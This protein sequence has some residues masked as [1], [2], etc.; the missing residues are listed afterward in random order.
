[1]SAPGDVHVHLQQLLEDLAALGG[2]IPDLARS[3]P[4]GARMIGDAKASE[5]PE[6]TA[7]QD[8]LAA[9]VRRLARSP[10]RQPDHLLVACSTARDAAAWAD[11]LTK[12]AQ[13][14]GL[15]VIDCRVHELACR[16]HI[17]RIVVTPV[18]T[19]APPLDD[20]VVVA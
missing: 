6:D 18:T 20:V 13:G 1:V 4:G 16:E 9:Y 17:G 14:S 19:S 2:L 10:G 5:G 3:G 12:L 7:S 8:R 15:T 11:V